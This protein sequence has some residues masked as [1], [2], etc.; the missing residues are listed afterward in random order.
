MISEFTERIASII[1]SLL[2]QP[3]EFYIIVLLALF[4]IIGIVIGISISTFDVGRINT[5]VKARIKSNTEKA[6]KVLGIITNIPGIKQIKRSIKKALSFN[7]LEDYQLTIRAD[8]LT[9]SLIALSAIA[10]TLLWKVG[11][12]WYVKLLIIA[13]SLFFPYYILTLILDMMKNKIQKQIPGL[14]DEFSSAFVNK[15]R[16]KDALIDT[17]KKLDKQ[18]GKIIEN[19]ADSPYI[20]DGLVALRDKLDNTWLNIF[21]TLI[22][23][24]KTSG[25]NLVEQLYH[26]KTTVARYNKIEKKKNKRLIGY[27][28]FAV[29][30]AVFGV[31]TCFWVNRAMFGN[32]IILVDAEANMIIARLIVLCILSLVV[33]RAVRR[34]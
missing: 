30:T 20:E 11:Q 21:V 15:P 10:L 1:K 17:S 13:I 9:L 32:D 5:Q 12:L 16:V 24:H 27:E 34:M 19:I 29:L 28:M 6:S 31:P 18:F 26:L 2:A 3:V 8:I 14:I 23:N 25:G 4:G 7:I 22:I 33:I